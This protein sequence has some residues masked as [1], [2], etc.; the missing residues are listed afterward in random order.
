M[1]PAE[2]NPQPQNANLVQA[3]AWLPYCGVFALGL[4]V[5]VLYL[6]NLRHSPMMDVV[7]GDAVEFDKWAQAIAKGDWIGDRPFQVAPLYQYFLAA[8]Y[9]VWGRDLFA[10]RCVQIV[11][12]AASCAFLAGAGCFFF[13]RKVGIGSGFLLAL[14]PP[15]VF[16]DG[17]IQK[18]SLDL[19]FM[20]L[21]LL[22]IGA[23][24][25]RQRWPRLFAAGLALGWLT[26]TRENAL[27]LAPLILI[28][29]FTRW[30]NEA[31]RLK[32][33]WSALFLGG[34]AL[35]LLPVGIRNKVVGG[36]F[37]LTSSN[38][39][40]NL[41]LGNNLKSDG[42]YAA[43]REER[44]SMN[45]ELEDSR[46][47]AEMDLGH[48]LTPREISHYWAKKS[49][50]YIRSNP[51]RFLKILGLKWT[52]VWNAGEIADT[53]DDATYYG[54]SSLL[55][56]LDWF[57][58]FGTLAAFALL[59]L[60]MSWDRR[61]TRW[62]LW[63]MILIFAL[64]VTAFIVFARYRY[65]MVP[66]LILYA[67]E[68]PF[69]IADSWRALNWKK[70]AWCGAVAAPA[71]LFFNW[72][73]KLD[74]DQRANTLTNIAGGYAQQGKTEEAI[75]YFVEAVKVNP[76]FNKA[77]YNIGIL[78]T[79]ENRFEEAE[80]QLKEAMRI[81]PS[82]DAYCA[83]G[84]NAM[85]RGKT[86]D[87]ISLFRQALDLKPDHVATHQY[88][89]QL[90]AD[91]GDWEGAVEH[92]SRALRSDP[93][94]ADLHNR[95]AV[96]LASHGRADEAM[97]HFN[98]ALQTDQANP[99]THNNM[100]VELAREGKREEA[101]DHF[102]T[103]LRVSPGFPGIHRNIATILEQMGKI[104]EAETHLREAIR[105]TPDDATSQNNLGVLLI[106]RGQVNEA[107]QHFAEA[108]RIKS[109]YA[110]AKQ[111]L[112]RALDAGA[113]LSSGGAT[114]PTLEAKPVEKAK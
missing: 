15:A 104:G 82:A 96:A 41:Y 51:G 88:L 19:F 71:A 23:F 40:L 22:F 111:N 27:V 72:P 5:R 97:K 81:Q 55:R 8:I 64:S 114:T 32:M 58:H 99:D 16:F 73:L 20:T 11:L 70:L 83:L 10:V 42:Y 2:P 63:T 54:Y 108:L 13:S 12:G 37:I 60:L 43:L 87:A 57:F 66:L 91:H 77:Y 93:R 48:S 46:A 28:W 100:A 29:I 92:F 98:A 38:F 103:V 34:F 4:A 9:A 45:Y 18:A 105:A 76:M 75:R 101:M 86:D 26:L 68:A 113:T 110:S 109:D 14:Y 50:D 33:I 85:R 53:E 17:L 25:E 84:Y 80:A 35:V 30:K 44:A 31:V 61:D 78:L 39:G 112:R 3:N 89:G 90:L 102:L 52:M 6:F 106:R 69:A 59:G 56:I 65:P 21:F 1:N 36:E 67:A 7:V 79:N 95:L 107:A 49:L 47:L 62:L 24:Q 94:N 74:F